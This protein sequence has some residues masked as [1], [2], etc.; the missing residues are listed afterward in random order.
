MF[1]KTGAAM[2]DNSIGSSPRWAMALF[3]T[4]ATFDF[5]FDFL[6]PRALTFSKIIPL[7]LR[8]WIENHTQ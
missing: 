4:V 8:I 1:L 5:T 2:V 6:K 3:N 7:E